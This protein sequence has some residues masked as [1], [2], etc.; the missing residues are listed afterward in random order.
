MFQGK[1]ILRFAL[2]LAIWAI[3]FLIPWQPV[4]RGYASIF[5]TGNNILFTRYWFWQEGT[6][7]FLDLHSTDLYR[8]ID[9]VTVGSL[10]PRFEP[11]KP[12]RVLDTLM[13]L[14]NRK[15]PGSFGMLRIGS[16]LVGYWSIAWLLALVLAKPMSWRRKGKAALWGLLWVHAFIAMRLTIKLGAD[17]FFAVKKYALFAPGEFSTDMLRRLVEVFLENPSVSFVVPTFI[18]FLVAFDRSEWSSLR[19]QILGTDEQEDN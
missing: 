11:P 4:V 13:V 19:Q 7:E 8:D 3:V 10:P 12:T 5:R 18:W 2:I 6:V 17:G 14:R 16:R 15:V 9:R 1:G